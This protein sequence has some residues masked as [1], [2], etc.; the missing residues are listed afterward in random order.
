VLYHASH[1]VAHPNQQRLVAMLSQ[2]CLGNNTS[3]AAAAVVPASAAESS[4]AQSKQAQHTIA[5]QWLSTPVP[6][7]AYEPILL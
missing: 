1:V 6:C 7:A 5:I 4:L 3:Q 2:A